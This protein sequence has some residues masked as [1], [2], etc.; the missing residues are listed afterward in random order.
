MSSSLNVTDEKYWKL[1]DTIREWL[2]F[3][4]NNYISI[5][6]NFFFLKESDLKFLL[7]SRISILLCPTV[8]Y[9]GQASILENSLEI[10]IIDWW[11][12]LVVCV[13]WKWKKKNN[14]VIKTLQA[15]FKGEAKD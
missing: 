13:L 4:I 11:Y 5:C 15:V 3:E 10:L 9:W 12:S 1:I 14:N 8:K 6:D 7:L 2:V